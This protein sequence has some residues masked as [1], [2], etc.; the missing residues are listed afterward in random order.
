VG[1]W[2]SPAHRGRCLLITRLNLCGEAP[3]DGER[4][5]ASRIHFHTLY[6][7][8]ESVVFFN[9]GA[10]ISTFAPAQWIAGIISYRGMKMLLPALLDE[11]NHFIDGHN[12]LLSAL[13]LR[14]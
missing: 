5:P 13:T 14:P 9:N 3:R 8:Q 4:L 12:N 7:L 10:L 6:F 1:G 11:F 2:P